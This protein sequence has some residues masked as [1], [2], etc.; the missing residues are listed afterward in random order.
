MTEIII[1]MISTVG[2]MLT[3]IVP[4]LIKSSREQRKSFELLKCGLKAGLKPQLQTLHGKQSY[5]VSSKNTHWDCQVDAIFNEVYVEYKKL[6]GNGTI[7]ALKC[8]MDFWREKY[9]NDLYD[10]NIV[11]GVE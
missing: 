11:E 6:G 2:S 7:D 1:T 8:D 9:A 5:L 10:K 3:V 4:I